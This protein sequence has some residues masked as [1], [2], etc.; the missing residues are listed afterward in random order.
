MSLKSVCLTL[1]LMLGTI[2]F[3]EWV[4]ADEEVSSKA[5]WHLDKA[6]YVESGLTVASLEHLSRCTRADVTRLYLR[7]V[8]E[9]PVG[10]LF[11]LTQLAELD[12][13]ENG[14]VEVPVSVLNMATL[15]RLWLVGN[16]IKELPM[17]IA[18]LKALVYLNL[19]RTILDKLPDELGELSNL[20]FLRLNDTSVASFPASL[21]KLSNMRRLY[22]RNTKLKDVP[23]VLASWRSLEDVIFAGTEINVVPDW[24]VSLPKLKRV[25]FAGCKQL[26]R[27]PEN[28]QG[29]RKLQVLD[30]SDTPLANDANERQRIRTA[31]GDDVTILF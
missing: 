1:S 10:Q 22:A 8:K 26:M 29:W 11:G 31:L 23:Q 25:S 21:G 4:K 7:G 2:C 20:R 27:L 5:E 19:D 28:L 17:D 14:L 6:R 18:Q 24:L 9:S 15:R 12:I 13:S 3:T 16:P 30:V